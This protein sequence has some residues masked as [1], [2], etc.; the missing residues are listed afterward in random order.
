M[1]KSKDV[2]PFYA[3][4]DIV[5]IFNVG[6]SPEFNPIESVFSQVKRIF[7][8]ERLNKLVNNE[9]FDTNKAIRAAFNKVSRDT[10]GACIK[11]SMSSLRVLKT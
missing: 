6:Y 5:P 9:E 10:V 11:K 2:R 4:L 8:R 1:H 7:C 3:S